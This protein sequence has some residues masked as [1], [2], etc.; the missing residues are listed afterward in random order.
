MQTSNTRQ[1]YIDRL[2]QVINYIHANLDRVLPLDALAGVAGF[3]P[4]HFHRI[5]KSLAGETL[6]EYILRARL[7]KSANLLLSHPDDT[8]IDILLA[9]GFSSPAVFSR[10]FRAHFGVSPSQF[11][12][13]K[14]SNPSKGDRKPGKD[15]FGQIGYNEGQRSLQIEAKTLPDMHVAYIRH[16]QG[17]RK[18]APDSRI[19]QAFERVCR[20][21]GA[22][23][24]FGPDTLVVG[25]PHD[26]PAI[27]PGDRCRYDACVTIPPE[28]VASQGAISVQDIPGCTYAVCRIE[29]G[30]S[31]ANRIGEMIDALYAEW[32]LEWLPDSGYQADDRPPLEIYHQAVD[33]WI[34]MDYC[35]PI[36]PL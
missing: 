3:S 1:A 31:E 6:G 35:I 27:T 7:E 5:F 30:A 20:W 36:K 9:C 18:G 2:N 28:I 14:K 29:A 22:R 13:Q 15:R 10:A 8:I 23:N 26:N 11:R 34:C 12:S 21:A 33:G 32:L 25:I 4:F 24:L 17:Y 19:G 16:I